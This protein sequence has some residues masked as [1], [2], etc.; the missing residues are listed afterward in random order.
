M[1]ED[2]N[3]IATFSLTVRGLVQGVGFRVFVVMAAN[4]LD[5]SGWVKNLP[6]GS[7]QLQATAPRSVLHKL[8]AVVSRG[9]RGSRIARVETEEIRTLG[10]ILSK[11]GKGFKIL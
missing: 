3:E 2:S 9:P 8:I 5:I 10:E 7:V 11:P 6:D 1:S 4:R